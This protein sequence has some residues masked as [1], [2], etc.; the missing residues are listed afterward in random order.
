MAGCT[1]P[2]LATT[3][4]YRQFAAPQ[5]THGARH[6]IETM[7]DPKKHH[8]SAQF[9]LRGWCGNA[10]NL[11]LVEYT[12]PHKTV[13]AKP[14]SPEATGFQ[15][16]LYTLN[17][18]PEGQRQNI[19]TKYMTPIV[20]TPGARALQILI[21]KM[22]EKLTDDVRRDWIR[23]ML[24]SKHRTPDNITRITREFAEKLEQ[25]LNANP[26]L[27]ESLQS[28]DPSTPYELLSRI[29][30]HLIADTAK[31]A[32]ILN[33]ENQKI[34][35]II[36]NME[37][38]TFDC[39]SS[40]HELMTS[41][42]PYFQTTGLRDQRCLVAFPLSPRFLFVATHDNKVAEALLSLGATATVSWVNDIIVRAANRYVYARTERHL[43]FVER[44]LCLPGELG[45]IVPP[46]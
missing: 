41:D 25:N 11:K 36:I 3:W 17:G 32:A 40:N 21:E 1:R 12:R 30:P 9:Y 27:Y 16:F 2:T 10:S 26:K 39:Q 8:F 42:A 43:K 34:S 18:V 5:G 13:V 7:N 38:W 46:Y 19:E 24:A 35:D 20:D 33:I 45:P 29:Q 4:A 22:G 44:R 23:F 15:E 31:Q 37:W 6:H 14:V 28:D